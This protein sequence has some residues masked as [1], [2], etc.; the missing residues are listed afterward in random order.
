MRDYVLT[1]QLKDWENHRRFR[2]TSIVGRRKPQV[3]IAEAR[4]AMKT[5]AAGLE[6]EYPRENKGRTAELFPL[7]E[8]ALGINQ[9]RQ[10]SLAG[11]VLMGVVGLVLLVPCDSL[12]N[13]VRAEAAK[14]DTEDTVAAAIG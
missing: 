9:R 12:A 5:I 14:R 13:L 6:K 10:F 7:N 1:G 8:S 2:W 4:A 3:G 11:G